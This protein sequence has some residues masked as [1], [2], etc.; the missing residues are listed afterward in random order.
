M[1]SASMPAAAKPA[2][3]FS[4]LWKN[5]GEKR[6]KSQSFSRRP[7]N[8]KSVGKL[9]TSAGDVVAWAV[10]GASYCDGRTHMRTLLNG[11]DLSVLRVSRSRASVWLV[12]L[13]AVVPISK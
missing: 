11:D 8:A 10:V 13:Y 12:Q 4:R 2:M 3:Q 5:A 9:V 1:T 7:S 6:V